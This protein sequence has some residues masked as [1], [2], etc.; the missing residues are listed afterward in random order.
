[1]DDIC[2][3]YMPTHRLIV[4]KNERM[5][6][7]SRTG[8]DDYAWPGADQRH[9]YTTTRAVA[10]AV[11][12]CFLVP[13]RIRGSSALMTMK[14]PSMFVRKT[15][16]KL[17]GSLC[18]TTQEQSWVHHA[19]GDIDR[20]SRIEA[21]HDQQHSR[22]CSGNH[23][24]GYASVVDENVE[25]LKDLVDFPGKCLHS[26][27][28]MSACSM[29]AFA[30]RMGRNAAQCPA[31]NNCTCLNGRALQNIQSDHGKC[32]IFSSKFLQLGSLLGESRG[33]CDSMSGLQHLD[34]AQHHCRS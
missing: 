26:A 2:T 27:H 18:M 4:C 31:S 23:G 3:I 29:R 9:C 8:R 14:H 22:L 6:R 19:T 13:L 7:C 25:S 5:A 33:R 20:R 10:S 16:G 12:T 1:M 17:P 21:G 24:T 11:R 32:C 30:V 28:D 15:G 34:D